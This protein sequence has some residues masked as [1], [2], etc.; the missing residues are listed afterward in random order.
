MC[1]RDLQ[2]IDHDDRAEYNK[3]FRFST[4]IGSPP[5]LPLKR[6]EKKSGDA[7]WER[8]QH[9]MPGTTYKTTTKHR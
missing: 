7:D 1:N 8:I 9:G 6:S 2:K 5:P 3:L 4:N